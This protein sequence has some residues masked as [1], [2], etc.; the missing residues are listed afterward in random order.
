MR[1]DAQRKR[2]N[3]KSHCGCFLNR[4]YVYMCVLLPKRYI[5]L[6]YWQDIEIISGNVDLK[7]IV[8]IVPLC[9]RTQREKKYK[10][11]SLIQQD[12]KHASQGT[13][14]YA[15][16]T[17][18]KTFFTTIT[19][20]DRDPRYM[21]SHYMRSKLFVPCKQNCVTNLLLNLL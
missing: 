12:I 16:S 17:W 5:F 21:L 6:F 4:Y 13:L 9:N 15:Q 2:D 19:F 1:S 20:R 11:W 7:M 8:M 3:A 14:N 10:G 18:C